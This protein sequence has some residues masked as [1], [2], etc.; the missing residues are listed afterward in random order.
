MRLS[1]ASLCIIPASSVVTGSSSCRHFG[2]FL[3]QE[4]AGRFALLESLLLTGVVSMP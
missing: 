1:L 2:A 4:L 3:R